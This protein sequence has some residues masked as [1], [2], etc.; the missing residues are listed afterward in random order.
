MSAV[1]LTILHTND[2]HDRRTVFPWLESYPRGANTLLLDAGDAIRGS[3]T[4][5]HW[6]EP[7]LDLMSRV[8]YDAMTLGNREFNYLRG[9]F[10]RRARQVNF[11]F[12]CANVRDLRGKV[13]DL[14]APTCVK[15]IGGVRV[16]LVGLTPVQFKDGSPW[17]TLFGYSFQAPLDVLPARVESLRRECDVVVLLSHSGFKRDVEIAR[18]VK[19]IDLIVGGHS[20]TRLEQPEVVEGT[21]IVQTGCY[22]RYVGKLQMRIAADGGTRVLDYELVPMAGAEAPIEEPRPVALA[23]GVNA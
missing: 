23:S 13:N 22:G 5:F 11:P 10:R 1:D 16:G 9:V 14:I 19:G 15:S 4:V 6:H 20:H 18:H 17:Q 12:V 2:M 21:P 8:G 7:M 3:N